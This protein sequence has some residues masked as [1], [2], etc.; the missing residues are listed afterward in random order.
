MTIDYKQIM[1]KTMFLRDNKRV[2]KQKRSSVFK[3]AFEQKLCKCKSIEKCSVWWI[4]AGAIARNKSEHFEDV[5]VYATLC[6]LQQ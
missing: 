2:A 5:G 1:F 6:A 3:E 4:L